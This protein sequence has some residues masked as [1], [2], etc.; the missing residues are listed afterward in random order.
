[1]RIQFKRNVFIECTLDVGDTVN[2]YGFSHKVDGLH[3][4]EDVVYADGYNCE[5][6][7]QVRVSGYPNLIDSNWVT[8]VKKVEKSFIVGGK[9]DGGNS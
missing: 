9:K 2:I 3:K 1:M 4:I 6:G 8:L 5:S 7:F